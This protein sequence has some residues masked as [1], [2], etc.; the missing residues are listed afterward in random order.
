MIMSFL[1]L[2]VIV[3]VVNYD[4]ILIYKYEFWDKVINNMIFKF[5]LFKYYDI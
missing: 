2:L 3:V 4:I 1:Y 5:L